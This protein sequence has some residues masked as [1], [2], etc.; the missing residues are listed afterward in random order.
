MYLSL[1]SKWS[2]ELQVS[3]NMAGDIL[4]SDAGDAANSHFIEGWM[5]ALPA[6]LVEVSD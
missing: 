3:G 2:K 5:S 6:V 1:R 4:I